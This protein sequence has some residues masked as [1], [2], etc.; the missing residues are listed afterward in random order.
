MPRLEFSLEGHP[1]GTT[2]PLAKLKA[3]GRVRLRVAFENDPARPI[4]V[5]GF[6]VVHNGAHVLQ[7][8]TCRDRCLVDLV[9]ESPDPTGY[10]YVRF[11]R[12]LAGTDLEMATSPIWI[13]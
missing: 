11:T 8:Q 12:D 1:M 4:T 6:D 10:W 9:V 7:R 13:E 3:P 2:I 5:A